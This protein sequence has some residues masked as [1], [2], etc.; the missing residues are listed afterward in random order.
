MESAPRLSAP[1]PDEADR[2]AR[3]AAVAL[4]R[5]DAAGVARAAA[6][7]EQIEAEREAAGLPPTGLA[8][9]ARDA[10]TALLPA[11]P[12]RRAAQKRVLKRRDAPRELATRL[13]QDVADDPLALARKRLREDRVIRWGGAA[14]E[15]SEGVGG[16]IAAPLFLPVRLAQALVRVALHLHDEE[17]MTPRERQALR[18][19]KDFVEEN[20]SAP[21]AAELVDKIE[22]AQARWI[23]MQVHRAVKQGEEALAEDEPILA[24][25]LA[26][27]ALR[28]RSEDARALSLL[29]RATRA[30]RTWNENR[31]RTLTVASPVAPLDD[32]SFRLA[33]ALLD[34][35]ADLGA[36]AQAVLDSRD[37]G[38]HPREIA[39]LSLALVAR[40]AGREDE[41]WQRLEAVAKRDDAVGRHAS[42]M[43]HDFDANPYLMFRLA[44]R[45]K[46]QENARRVLLGPLAFGAHDHDLPHPVEWLA[47]VPTLTSVVLGLPSRL[48][49]FPYGRSEKRAAAALGRRYL[50]R[51]PNGAHAAE[52]RVWLLDYEKARG[53]AVG[54]LAIAEGTDA[55]GEKE[56]AELREDAAK[57]VVAAANRERTR[58]GRVQL[59]AR[60]AELFPETDAAR[61]ARESVR[62]EVER[63]T[64]Q[65]IRVSREYLVENPEVAGPNGFALQ[66]AL[67]DGDV[68]N[69][70]LHEDGITLIGGRWIELAYVGAAGKNG[71]P[72]TRRVEVSDEHL[73]RIAAAL[74]ESALHRT[75]VD[76]DAT[77]PADAARETFFER[78]RLGLADQALRAGGDSEFAF[79][80]MREM[81]GIVRARESIL[82]VELVLQ[83]GLQ[84]F[85]FGAFP[86]IR[87]PKDTPDQI[88]YR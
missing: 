17:A 48:L 23:E 58:A 35:Q 61:A 73:A 7:L 32:A 19:W 28:Y 27:R 9:Y 47:E 72:E 8:A 83:S 52:V 84:D 49:A 63:G 74:E 18:H 70:E 14:N 25:F 59:L 38:A 60:A 22:A 69:G 53:N 88:L 36:A 85:G 21:E 78:A 29:E 86:R 79:R 43:L 55:L 50:E 56:R 42:A 4:W 46:T 5:S 64:P 41:S 31:A 77:F 82:P 12:E 1:L 71:A 33:R 51:N 26:E 34:P 81:Y 13:E 11:G 80:G 67:L 65:H 62:R 20:P 39:E 44:R 54:A 2:A 10:E 3:D 15:V 76:R 16:S 57:Q 66:A 75:R 40:E 87:M 68:R 45:E 6:S 37:A 30:G 24:A